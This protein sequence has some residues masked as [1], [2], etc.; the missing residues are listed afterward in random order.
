[1]L[2]IPDLELSENDDELDTWF[3]KERHAEFSFWQPQ[4]NVTEAEVEDPYR[5]VLFD[6]VRPFLIEL[7]SQE[8]QK[9]LILEFLNF[10]GVPLLNSETIMLP[11]FYGFWE[12]K[13]TVGLFQFPDL[14][15]TPCTS[16]LQKDTHWFPLLSSEHISF[17]E[18]SGAYKKEFIRQVYYF[19][20]SVFFSKKIPNTPSN[21]F[22][23]ASKLD[24]FG[25]F[26]TTAS[27]AF[28]SFFGYKTAHKIAKSLLK[29]ER[30]NLLLW[31]TFAHLELAEGKVEE[32]SVSFSLFF[33]NFVYNH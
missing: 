2:P 14:R 5:A 23:Q 29:Q 18:T 30:S 20:P 10:L 6:D 13:E 3:K 28:E 26:M 25:S 33:I 24:F 27:L 9:R 19:I 4:I 11:E 1:M 31:N 12:K 22:Q 15:P 32:V 8:A 21:I 16:H 17:I 7:N